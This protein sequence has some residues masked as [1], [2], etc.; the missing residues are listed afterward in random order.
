MACRPQL[1]QEVP[2]RSRAT[3]TGLPTEPPALTPRLP[4]PESRVPGKDQEGEA[5]PG[6]DR[7]AEDLSGRKHI[8]RR[9]S[10][11]LEGLDCSG[12][13]SLVCTRAPHRVNLH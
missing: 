1:P 11:F 10:T 12:D 4:H 8:S 6:Q 13:W 9:P 7:G 5:S 3:A 2:P